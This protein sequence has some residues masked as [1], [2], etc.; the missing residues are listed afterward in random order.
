MIKIIYD[1]MVWN[2]E[3]RTNAPKSEVSHKELEENLV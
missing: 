1:N 3:K 2:E